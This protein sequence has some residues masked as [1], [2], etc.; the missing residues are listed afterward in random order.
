[1][2]APA[3]A[4]QPV[5]LRRGV[6]SSLPAGIRAPGYD[7]STVRPGIVHLGLGRFHRA[8]MARYTHELME[9]DPGALEWR[10]IAAGLLPRD[11]RMIESLA[12]QDGLYTLIEKDHDS[13]QARIVGSLVG[14]IFAGETT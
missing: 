14:L 10:I 12:A 1:M 5:P 6:L 4:R 8:H 11:R 7:V 3:A 2:S 13:E 9:R